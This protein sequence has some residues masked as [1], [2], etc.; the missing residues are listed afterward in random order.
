MT[1]VMELFLNQSHISIL[2]YAAGSML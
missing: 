2:Q 1:L